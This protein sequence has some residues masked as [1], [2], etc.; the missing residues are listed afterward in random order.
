MLQTTALFAPSSPDVIRAKLI[1]SQA[2]F[3]AVT[4]VTMGMLIFISK[5]K[6]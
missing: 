3:A 6:R 1:M 2:D 5:Y 4:G